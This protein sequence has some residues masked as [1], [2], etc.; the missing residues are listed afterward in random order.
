MKYK[1]TFLLIEDNL[2]DQL[3]TRQ[4]LKKFFDI[5]D[6]TI[7]NNGMEALEWLHN[8]QN[9]DQSLIILTD[10]QMPIMNGLEFLEEY[11]KLS[12]EFKEI[13]QIYILSSTMDQDEIKRIKENNDVMGFL[14][15]PLQ[16]DEFK[17]LFL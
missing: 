13:A 5:N 12:P 8:N 11:R 3:V 16:M 6:V 9:L 4:L 14:N 15:K 10:I 7:A 17:N 1:P 2:I